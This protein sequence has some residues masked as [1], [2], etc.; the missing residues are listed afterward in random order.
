MS[1]HLISIL[2]I[3]VLF[4]GVLRATAEEAVES[5]VPRPLCC[6]NNHV[7]KKVS[8]MAST[9]RHSSGKVNSAFC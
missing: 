5:G 4:S 1:A 2:L 8:Y 7:E 9:K 3:S 6:E